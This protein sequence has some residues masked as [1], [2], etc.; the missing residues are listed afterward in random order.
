MERDANIQ[1]SHSEK[2][3]LRSQFA[4]NLKDFSSLSVMLRHINLRQL[5]KCMVKEKCAFTSDDAVRFKNHL[6]ERHGAMVKFLKL[7]VT[8]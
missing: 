1:L 8:K 5:F 7:S 4:S 6:N 3:S 2:E